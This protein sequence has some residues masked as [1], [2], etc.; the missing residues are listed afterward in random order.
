FTRDSYGTLSRLNVIKGRSR[1]SGWDSVGGKSQSA[2]QR[3]LAGVVRNAEV[4]GEAIPTLPFVTSFV[5]A[6]LEREGEGRT[7]FVIG[8]NL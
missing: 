1:N 2:V 3:L 8:P 5:S 7:E 6:T 4:R